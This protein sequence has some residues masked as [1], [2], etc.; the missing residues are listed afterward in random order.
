MPEAA[1]HRAAPP[2]VRALSRLVR[3]MPIGRYRLIHESRRFAIAPFVGYLSDDLGGLAFLC[4]PRDSV[5][6]E[7]C[8][9]GVYEP[10]ET[11]LA[12]LILSR[13]DVFVDIGAN[14]GY[15]TL[16][17]SHWTGPSGRVVAFE[18]HP[19]LFDLLRRNLALNGL[20][21]VEA[22]RV[23]V[24]DC[25]GSLAFTAF[26]DDGDNWGLSRT[27]LRGEVADFNAD[28]VA[29][30]DVLDASGI[31][32]VQLTKI[33][34]EGGEA[35]VLAGMR[36]G[37]RAGRYRYILIEC[38]PRLLA[39]RGHDEESTLRPIVDAG[40]RV[41]TVVHTPH[42]HRLAA[43]RRLSSSELLEPCAHGSFRHHWP[44][45]LAAA[46]GAPDLP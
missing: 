12:S 19:R 38:H 3:W 36:R 20:R 24:S 17:A 4:D 37:L 41:S 14:W 30:D 34:V 2:A 32:R 1:R 31:E 43:R 33:D 35:A 27:A 7:V 42:L 6:R 21:G 18:P 13:G 29:L 46:P 9:T 44:H 10:Q 23:A 15:F 11:Q 45:L 5:A 22:H 16:A 26:R 40:Y 8:Y 28:A 25:R 39:A